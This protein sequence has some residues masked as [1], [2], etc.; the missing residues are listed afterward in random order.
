MEYYYLVNYCSE[1]GYAMARI[2]R[3]KIINSFEDLENIEECLS[4]TNNIKAHILNYQLVGSKEVTESKSETM[5]S[6]DYLEYLKE[7]VDDW[8][9]E[10]KNTKKKSKKNELIKQTINY[11]KEVIEK[12]NGIKDNETGL[13]YTNIC[14][15]CGKE[16]KVARKN[17]RFCDEKCKKEYMKKYRHNYYENMSAEDKE[18]MNKESVNRMKE[19]RAKRKE[20]K[21]CKK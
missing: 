10:L 8:L 7:R 6:I 21:N 19:L 14:K 15:N 3:N 18:K 17:I 20:F 2:G 1:R 16:I 11:A 13:I 9:E 5:D 12:V 4:T